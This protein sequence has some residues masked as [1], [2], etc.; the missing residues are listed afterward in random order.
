MFWVVKP[1]R[2]LANHGVC[3]SLASGFLLAGESPAK[4]RRKSAGKGRKS[5]G[6]GR[7]SLGKGDM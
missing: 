3:A 7:K 5:V 4:E 1:S 6:K 2:S